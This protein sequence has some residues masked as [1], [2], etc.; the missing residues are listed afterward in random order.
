MKFQNRY[1]F[2]FLAKLPLLLLYIS[3]FTVQLFYNFDIANHPANTTVV[4][5]HKVQ[6]QKDG[7]LTLK[8]ATDTPGKNIS[9]RLNKRYHPQPAITCNEVIIKQVVCYVSS[10]L[11]VH[12]S[13]GF[14]PS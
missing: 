13:S 4:S 6:A 9:F 14:T 8:K 2:F 5:L 11:H 12:Y 3:F 10:K 7:P 1:I